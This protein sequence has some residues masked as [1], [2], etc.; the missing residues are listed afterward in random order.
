MRILVI[1]DTHKKLNHVIDLLSGDHRFDHIIHLGDLVSDARDIES[2]FELPVTCVR[3]NCDYYELEARAEEVLEIGGIR[4]MACH[5]HLYHVKASLHGLRK[6]ID[7]RD[8]DVVLYG[9]THKSKIEYHGDGIIMNPGSIGLPRDG[10]PSFGVIHI[11]STG[12]V[13]VNIARIS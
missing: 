9:H 1:S 2:V 10:A 12:K 11:E 4:I 6:A 8:M 13:H 5:G 3:G 7:E